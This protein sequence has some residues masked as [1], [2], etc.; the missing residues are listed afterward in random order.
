MKKDNKQ[1]LK[2]EAKGFW[3]DFKAFITRGNVVDLS[4]AVVVGGAFGK[5]TSGLVNFIINPLI[6]LLTGGI[7]LDSWRT[8][9]GAPQ[10]DAAGAYLLDEFGG[11]VYANYIE[12]GQFIQTI[13]DFLIISFCIFAVVRFMRRAERAL[14]I[15][16]IE[17]RE[18]EAAKLKAEAETAAEAQRKA[19]AEKKAIEDEFYANVKE[20]TALLREIRE[21]LKQ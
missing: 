17:K 7:S 16:E 3:K 18:A 13:I 1:S 20:Q 21:R 4:V 2:N 10:T 19:E 15:K 5:I 6:A 8:P 14:M 11:Y 12:W 9:L